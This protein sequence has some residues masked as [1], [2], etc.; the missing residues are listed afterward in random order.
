M[1]QVQGLMYFVGYPQGTVINGT[2]APGY[3]T[4]RIADITDGTSNTF[5]FGERAH[6]LLPDGVIHDWQW[7]TSGNYGD[8]LFNTL[9]P[10]NPHRKI[11]NWVNPNSASN[12][13]GNTTTADPLGTSY[14]TSCLGGGDSSW[15]NSA[16]SFHPGGANFCFSDG[17]VRFIKDSI[18]SW[19]IGACLPTGVTRTN[20][21]YT[22]AP[23]SKVGVYQALSTRNGGEVI[24]SDAY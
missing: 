22:I 15:V 10:V 14:N 21:I 7:W 18:D 12:Y 6:G 19:Q 13:P 4:V 23:G 8:T 20:G 3:T 11:K 2:P 16:S 9:H 5:A 1:G 24:S 17:S